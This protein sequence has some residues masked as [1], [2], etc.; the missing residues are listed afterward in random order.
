MRLKV[1]TLAMVF[2][3][4]TGCQRHDCEEGFAPAKDGTCLPKDVRAACDP[5]NPCPDTLL[6]VLP[7][8]EPKGY[9]L[10]TCELLADD[11]SQLDKL[12]EEF[13]P[14]VWSCEAMIDG[15]DVCYYI[16]DE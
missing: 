5:F 12:D 3:A 8:E 15:P 10:P 2:I 11:C 4:N 7:S 1:I 6:C 9:C 13:E 16:S 14:G